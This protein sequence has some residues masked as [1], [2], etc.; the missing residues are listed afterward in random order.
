M[1]REG[2]YRNS[3]MLCVDL[4]KF[5]AAAVVFEVVV[6]H[7]VRHLSRTNAVDLENLQCKREL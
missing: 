4:A 7:V 6:H 2:V 5:L 1:N 3:E